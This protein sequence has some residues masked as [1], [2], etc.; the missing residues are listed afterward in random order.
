[1]PLLQTHRRYLGVIIMVLLV[2]VMF[3]S[4]VPDPMGAARPF[5]WAGGKT[6]FI[7]RA[8]ALSRAISNYVSGNFGYSRSMPYLRGFIGNV[9]DAPN[10]P[11]VYYGRN[12]RLY[13]NGDNAVGQSSGS[14]YRQAAVEHFAEVADAMR[15]ALAASGG[16][17]V[18][19]IP[20]NSQSM[21]SKDLPA[22]WR[23]S[24]SL[25]YD[26]AIRELRQ[27]GITTIDL[28]ATFAAMPD[29]DNLY[30]RTDTHWRWKAALLAYNMAM[31]A[32]GHAEW[33]LDPATTLGPLA[34]AP[35]GDLARMLAM[36]DS[37]SDSDYALNLPQL[38]SVWKPTDTFRSPPFQD[39]FFPYASER[40]P[41]G[42]G[43]LVL[44]DS[45][46]MGFWRPLLERSGASRTGW[47]HFALCG[48]DFRDLERFKPDYVIIAP[49]ERFMPCPPK[50]WPNGLSHE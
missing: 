20:P 1:M 25:E 22:W 6:A 16:K 36:S 8:N 7:D 31:Q 37:F 29:V 46:T 28:K 3:G 23:I 14:V 30:L 24:G 5:T 44:G 12:K 42:V 11:N 45:F 35:S 32:I 2:L 19:M 9:F 26:L 18:V 50:N 21:P 39:A 47:M 4:L 10:H 48:F 43:I 33:S 15:R 38:T 41:D 13:F 27:R 34:P 17:L 49:T 40:A